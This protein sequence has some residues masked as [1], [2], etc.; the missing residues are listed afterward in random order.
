MC[1]EKVG[2]QGKQNFM[3]WARLVTCEYSQVTWV[4]D[5]FAPVVDD[6][7]FHFLLIAMIVWDLKAKIIDVETAFL[8]G[9]LKE[10]FMSIP[11]GMEADKDECLTLKKTIY[12]LVQSSRHFYMKLVEALES[13]G[14]KASQIDGFLWIKTTSSG[15]ALMAIYVDNWLTIGTDEAINEVIESLKDHGF[16]F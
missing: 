9:E 16:G 5:N 3:F 6:V 8:H 12:G 7:S 15:I 14:F 11:P 10:I 1:K 13:C 4:D 2:V